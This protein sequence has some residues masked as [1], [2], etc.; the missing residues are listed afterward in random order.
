MAAADTKFINLIN[1]YKTSVLDSGA[2]RNYNKADDNLQLTG[3]ASKKVMIAFGPAK[4]H[5]LRC[6]L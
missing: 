1:K 4:Q 5:T 3:D 6:L 2:T